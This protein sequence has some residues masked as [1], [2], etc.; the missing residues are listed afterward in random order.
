MRVAGLLGEGEEA[1]VELMKQ[2]SH[3]RERVQQQVSALTHLQRMPPRAAGNALSARCASPVAGASCGLQ[4]SEA[5]KLKRHAVRLLRAAMWLLPFRLRGV[6]AGAG[7]VFGVGSARF[8][9]AGP[10]LLYIDTPGHEVL[11]DRAYQY[12]MTMTGPVVAQG[13]AIAHVYPVRMLK[14]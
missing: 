3:A 12:T 5:R 7:A 9:G 6:G 1:E 8:L 14:A 4:D 13:P 11:G 10:S 2:L